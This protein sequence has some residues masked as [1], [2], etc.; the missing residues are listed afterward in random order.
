MQPFA[1]FAAA[2]A[3][4]EAVPDRRGAA[5]LRRGGPADARGDPAFLVRAELDADALKPFPGVAAY[6]WM[7]AGVRIIGGER[8]AL[9]F[10]ISP[11]RDGRRHATR[12]D[13]EAE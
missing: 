2:A 12:E 4:G 1:G 6:A 13:Q 9:D 3:R 8:I 11:I 10:I 5:R 7:P